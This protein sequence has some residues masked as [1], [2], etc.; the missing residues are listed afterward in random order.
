MSGSLRRT[1]ASPWLTSCGTP[2]PTSLRAS[3]AA[4]QHRATLCSSALAASAA[5]PPAFL[6]SVPARASSCGSALSSRATTSRKT[7]SSARRCSPTTQPTA[8]SRGAS[9][10]MSRSRSS[11]STARS[12]SSSPPSPRRI[13]TT[14][15][16]ASRT[17]SSLTTPVP[18]PTW[19][20]SAATS[21]AAVWTRSF[22]LP[23]ARASPTS[24]TASIRTSLTCKTTRSSP[25]LPVP[26]TL[27][28]P[29]S[30]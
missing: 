8:P 23:Q 10:A 27:S 4:R 17:R 18:S 19:R 24:S 7:F 29:S 20:R 11:S 14:P 16:L 6:F 28:R 1:A 22:S 9:S 3:S 26:P 21:R 12:S 5:W 15:S 25:L 13:S 2:S 30:R